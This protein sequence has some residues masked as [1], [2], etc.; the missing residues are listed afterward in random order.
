MPQYPIATYMEKTQ[1]KYA[2]LHMVASVCF[3]AVTVIPDIET[4][5]LTSGIFGVVALVNA[6]AGGLQLAKYCTDKNIGI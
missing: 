6:F 3:L 5:D 4:S 2:I 1:L